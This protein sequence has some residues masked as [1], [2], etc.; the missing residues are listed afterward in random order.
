MDVQ[1][2]PRG[3]T[4]VP[5]LP[6]AAATRQNSHV[7]FF[8]PF[9]ANGSDDL[10]GKIP[11]EGADKL[12]SQKRKRQDAPI[13]SNAT[14][15]EALKAVVRDLARLSARNICDGGT[16]AALPERRSPL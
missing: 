2:V 15:T 11:P 1:G 8:D 10:T 9:S 16:T 5:Q 13:G 6:A 4:G 7:V 14:R 3:S 12:A